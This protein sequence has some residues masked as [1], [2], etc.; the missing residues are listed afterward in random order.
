MSD[1][2]ITA[3]LTGLASVSVQGQGL[4]TVEHMAPIDDRVLR[5]Y[6]GRSRK[7]STH[8]VRRVQT[9]ILLRD[10]EVQNHST[11]HGRRKHRD[12]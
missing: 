11:H 12:E 2:L 7:N 8:E 6:E 1:L 3:L 9:D 5:G 10:L 4:E